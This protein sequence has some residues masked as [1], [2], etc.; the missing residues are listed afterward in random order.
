M[1]TVLSINQDW[2]YKPSFLQQSDI[3]SAVDSSYTAIGL[4]HTN[5]ELPYNYFDDTEFCFESCYKRVL[6][7]DA[8]WEGQ[9]I[10]LDFEGVMSY[11]RVFINGSAVGEHKGG[12]TPF[13]IEITDAV[14]CGADNNLTVA[15]DSS[16]RPDIPPFGG[17]IDYLTYGGIYREVQLRVVSSTFIQDV[18]VTTPNALDKA[19][20][21]Y[22]HVKI[23]GF[24]DSSDLTIK[25]DLFDE[26]MSLANISIPVSNDTATQIQLDKLKDIELWSLENPK[27]YRVVC[28][29]Y[30]N[31]KEIDSY[32]V[33]M[34]F[35]DI[36]FV[37]EGFFLNGKKP[38]LPVLT[39]IRRTL[40]WDMP[41]QH[42]CNA[43]MQT[44]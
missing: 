37:A 43:K 35:R 13:S 24:K 29:L 30:Q 15:V 2:F 42:V 11:A 6:S 4:P 9:R 27:L 19:K 5:I 18:F 16:E 20:Q 38:S 33:R 7:I 26:D 14:Q 36:R 1:R 25:M 12:Y 17:R 3:G 34:G 32:A 23:S 31:K 44:L 21:L 8:E 40:M 10:F 28:T 22:A 39:A 41:C